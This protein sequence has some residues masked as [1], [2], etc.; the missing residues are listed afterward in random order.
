MATTVIID[1]SSWIL[2]SAGVL[3]GFFVWRQLSS[4]AQ[5]RGRPLPPGPPGWPIIGNVLDVPSRDAH[6]KYAEL[7]KKYGAYPRVTIAMDRSWNEKLRRCRIPG[8]WRS[9]D[10]HP[11]LAT[12]C[13]RTIPPSRSGLLFATQVANPRY[14]CVVENLPRSTADPAVAGAASECTLLSSHTV[15]S[16]AHGAGHSTLRTWQNTLS[17]ITPIIWPLCTRS[18]RMCWR[19]RKM[20]SSSADSAWNAI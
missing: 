6:V 5:R 2:A 11:R 9:A 3:I 15:K 17:N 4:R 19:D 13:Y 16:G 18:C 10:G 7:S 14:V 12:R 8:R 20:S 1:T